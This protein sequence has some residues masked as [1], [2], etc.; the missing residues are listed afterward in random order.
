[1]A[2]YKI[3]DDYD[4]TISGPKKLVKGFEVEGTIFN[5]KTGKS[6]GINVR[7]EGRTISSAHD[8]ARAQALQLC[9][10]RPDNE[11]SKPRQGRTKARPPSKKKKSKV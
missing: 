10:L 9:S 2:T 5:R 4:V 6:T 7:G 8:R 3:N 11:P 1:M